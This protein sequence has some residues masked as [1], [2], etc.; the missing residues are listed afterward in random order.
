MNEKEVLEMLK[1]GESSK[2]EFKQ[3]GVSPDKMASKI[4]AF[5]NSEGGTI[6]FGVDDKGNPVGIK[7]MG[8]KDFEEWIMNISRNNCYPSI[9]PVFEKMNLSRNVI[10]I[11][12]IPKREGIVHRAIDGRYYIRVGTTV[13][14]ATPEE[15]ARLFQLAGMVHYDI[16]PVYN[17]SISDI[18]KSRLKHY[19]FKILN[20]KFPQKKVLKNIK[21]MTNVEGQD[22]L[23]VSA[24]LVFGINPQ[25]FLPQ[26]E[27]IA[28]KFRGE[29]MD[30]DSADR[31]Q[32]S[33]PLINKYNPDNG[34]IVEEGIIDLAVR[35]VQSN[36]HVA[37]KMRGIRRIDTPQY[38]IESVRE[39]IVNAVSH[40]NYAIMGAKIR[41]FIFSNRIEIHSP[42]KLPNTVTIENM[43]ESAH[44]TRNPELY[45]LLAQYKYAEDIGLGIP[46]KVIRKMVEHN[47]KEP[48]LEEKGEEF[49]VTLY[50]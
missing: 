23:T 39:I 24:L 2:V 1:N 46:E 31:R 27:I 5:A 19:F 37:S 33:G 4:V 12:T 13:R 3:E 8:I 32:I 14:D 36:A 20:R 44:Y 22:C 38:P 49:I 28:V 42:G 40:R 30:Y 41:L 21:I 11:I 45:K 10:A 34:E 6:F 7:K 9:N 17:T 26:A 50:G 43:K 35:F 18:D 47:G 48:R 29:E 16:T 25:K 15:L